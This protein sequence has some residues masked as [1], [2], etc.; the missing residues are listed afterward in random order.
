MFSVLQ[1]FL[2][3]LILI[4]VI[5]PTVAQQLP[6]TTTTETI[7][8]ADRH[9]LVFD[10]IGHMAS[11]TTYIHAVIPINISSVTAQA[12]PLYDTFTQLQKLK[13]QNL[14]HLPFCKNMYEIG[15]LFEERLFTQ[16]TALKKID[17]ILPQDSPN[18]LH[19]RN[20][21]FPIPPVLIGVLTSTWFTR[22]IF[23]AKSLTKVASVATI[24]GTAGHLITQSNRQEAA[25]LKA[26]DEANKNDIELNELIK[27]YIKS[28][29]KN[30][31]MRDNAGV[32]ADNLMKDNLLMIQKL[33]KTMTEAKNVLPP[34]YSAHFNFDQLVPLPPPRGW[35]NHPTL[36]Q[37]YTDDLEDANE[38]I[39]KQVEILK[40]S[41]YVTRPHTTRL[42]RHATSPSS[43]NDFMH[44]FLSLTAWD[45]QPFEFPSPKEGT[46]DEIIS[47]DDSPSRNPRN[48]VVNWGAL[49]T[50]VSGT[51]L[52]LYSTIESGLLRARLNSIEKAHNL[53]VLLSQKQSR[54][55]QE[56]IHS[57]DHFLRTIELILIHDA[58][59]L[60]AQLDRIMTQWEQQ[61]RMVMDAIQQAQHQKLAINLL[62]QDQLRILHQATLDLA[63]RHQY[64]VLPQQLSDYFQL[65]VSYA[66]SGPD[67]LLIV[68]VPCVSTTCS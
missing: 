37:T 41:P 59:V 16:L 17:G 29:Q 7:T 68:H 44:F 62:D 9:Y 12:Q 52:G 35:E 22:T 18:S 26:L 25:S 10:K 27:Q 30:A 23:I 53:L 65:D 47:V 57:L 21:R 60:Y 58:G 20:K 6:T 55:N 34:Q 64:Q 46:D 38:E 1:M 33:N 61:V 14:T 8:D 42:P 66:R 49:A 36:I 2:T 3:F 56:I 15:K 39:R 54:T 13:T 5:L 50:V 67:V 63:A 43:F 45:H 24:F 51:F 11:S 19:S 4:P 31:L 32:E 40:D 48:A 28:N